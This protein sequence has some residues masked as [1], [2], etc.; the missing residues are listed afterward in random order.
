[1]RAVLRF[2]TL[3]AVTLLTLNGFLA[4][5]LSILL[6]FS[7]CVNILLPTRYIGLVIKK[8]TTS[9]LHL[10]TKAWLGLSVFLLCRRMKAL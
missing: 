10:G 3:Q 4:G 6:H 2:E 5:S 7:F 1:M 9:Q 8:I